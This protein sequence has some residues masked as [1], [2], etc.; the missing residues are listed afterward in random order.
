M[1]FGWFWDKVAQHSVQGTGFVSLHSARQPLTLFVT[2]RGVVWQNI[3]LTESLRVWGWLSCLAG[4]TA[5]GAAN[6]FCSPK[7]RKGV[8]TVSVKMYNLRYDCLFR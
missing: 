3:Q 8:Y 5:V 2:W 4:V 1:A 7:N 6:R